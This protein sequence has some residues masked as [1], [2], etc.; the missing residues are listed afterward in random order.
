MASI[1]LPGVIMRESFDRT[2]WGYLTL[3][4]SGRP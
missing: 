1:V 3:A 2:L 4:D